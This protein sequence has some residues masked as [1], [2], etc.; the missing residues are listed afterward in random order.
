[1]QFQTLK[2]LG[3]DVFFCL[4][5]SIQ[6]LCCPWITQKFDLRLHKRDQ[7]RSWTQHVIRKRPGMYRWQKW[8]EKIS[9]SHTVVLR[10]VISAACSFRYCKLLACMH[11]GKSVLLKGKSSAFVR[12][13]VKE[14]FV[15]SLW[16]VSV[17]FVLLQRV[18]S[19]TQKKTVR[20]PS[21]WVCFDVGVF[22]NLAS[23]TKNS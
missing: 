16:N 12:L 2:L 7:Y 19:P 9:N 10:T 4:W 17:W 6:N 20:W 21:V 22:C 5:Y 18:Q 8:E 23:E 1:M 13:W 11:K 3:A 15:E 14:V